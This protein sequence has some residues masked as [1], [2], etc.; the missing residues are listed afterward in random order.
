[1]STVA[2][3]VGASTRVVVHS[4][5]A[6]WRN[7]SGHAKV[8]FVAVVRQ[9]TATGMAS[10]RPKC[11]RLFGVHTLT[12]PCDPGARTS[13]TSRTTYSGAGPATLSW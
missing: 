8:P 3:F 9:T 5:A 2:A 11:T 12:V 13:T 4:T 10:P 1:M 6:A 7:S